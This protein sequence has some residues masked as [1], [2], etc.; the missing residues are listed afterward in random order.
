MILASRTGQLVA[1]GMPGSG[2]TR[3]RLSL[4]LP[5]DI[6]FKNAIDG[7][8]RNRWVVRGGR[9]SVEGP[10]LRLGVFFQKRRR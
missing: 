5:A 4:P 9:A 1:P 10:R 2:S 6:L 3:G 7:A 8:M